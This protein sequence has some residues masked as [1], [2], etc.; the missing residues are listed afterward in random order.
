M[1]CSVADFIESPVRLAVPPHID[2]RLPA[3][4]KDSQ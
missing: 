3:N 4:R 2:S 1:S